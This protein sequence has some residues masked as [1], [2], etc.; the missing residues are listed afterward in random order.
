MDWNEWIQNIALERID[1]VER[2]LRSHPEQF[3]QFNTATEKLDAAMS[4]ADS[5]HDDKLIARDELWMAYCAA[6]ALEMY[7]AGARDGGRVCHAFISGELPAIQ[8]HE[9]DVHE[10]SIS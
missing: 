1:E 2:Y 5:E 9:E 3:P 10:Q 6:Q 4:V 7:L 8:K